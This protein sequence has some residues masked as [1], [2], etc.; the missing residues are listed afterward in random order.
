[1]LAWMLVGACGIGFIV[2]WFYTVYKELSKSQHSLTIQ[3][4]Q[5]LMN[6][7]TSAKIRDARDREVAIRMLETNRK[8]YK[9]AVKNHNKLLKKHLNHIPAFLMGFR[10][11]DEVGTPMKKNN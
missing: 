11:A 4:E 10:P 3:R 8:I 2:I 7:T 9:E 1:M 6:E 5:L